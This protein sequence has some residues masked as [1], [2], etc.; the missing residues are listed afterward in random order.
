MLDYIVTGAIARKQVTSAARPQFGTSWF[1]RRHNASR[2][3]KDRY[4]SYTGPSDLGSG[5]QRWYDGYNYVT[6]ETHWYQNRRFGPSGNMI[7]AVDDES[8][9]KP[10]ALGSMHAGFRSNDAWQG[11]EGGPVP[12]GRFGFSL[13]MSHVDIPGMTIG[14]AFKHQADVPSGRY[15]YVASGDNALSQG[16][17]EFGGHVDYPDHKLNHY[18]YQVYFSETG[19]TGLPTGTSGSDGSTQSTTDFRSSGYSFVAGDIGKFIKVTNG[20]SEADEYIYEITG[21]NGTDAVTDAVTVNQPF[22]ASPSTA[23]NMVWEMV[24]G[25]IA[26]YFWRKRAYKNWDRPSAAIITTY[27]SAAMT[28]GNNEA[29]CTVGDPGTHPH[30]SAATAAAPDGVGNWWFLNAMTNYNASYYYEED[31]AISLYRYTQMSPEGLDPVYRDNDIT[32]MPTGIQW[33]RDLGSDDQHDIWVAWEGTPDAPNANKRVAK[34][35]PHPAGDARYPAVAGAGAALYEAQSG[36]ADAT[37]LCSDVPAGIVCDYLNG[38]TWIFHDTGSTLAT[39]QDN[40]GISYTE[41]GGTTWKRIHRLHTITGETLTPTNGV[42]TVTG[43]TALLSKVAPGDWIRFAGDTRSYEVD[44][45]PDNA[46]LTLVINY[47]G[48]GGSPLSVEKGALNGDVEALA[49]HGPW[50]T[51]IIGWN[52]DSNW[53]RRLAADFDRSGNVYWISNDRSAVMKWSPTD[54]TVTKI[55]EAGLPTGGWAFAGNQLRSV[56][57]TKLPKLSNRPAARMD[58]NIWVCSS[59]DG[60]ARIPNTNFE[61]VGDTGSMTDNGGTTSFADLGGTPNKVQVHST[62]H[63]LANGCE[64]YISGTTNYNGEYVIENVTADTFDIISPYVAEGVAGSWQVIATKYHYNV[65]DNYPLTGDIPSA[66]TNRGMDIAADETSGAIYLLTSYAGANQQHWYMEQEGSNRGVWTYLGGWSSASFTNVNNRKEAYYAYAPSLSMTF[67]RDN[68]SQGVTAMTYGTASANVVM[69]QGSVWTCFGWDGAAW[70]EMIGNHNDVDIDFDA[71]AGGPYMAE[72][73][74][75]GFGTRRVFSDWVELEHGLMV[76]FTQDGTVAQTSEF[77]QDEQTTVPVYVGWGKDNISDA[78]YSLGFMWSPTVHRQGVE[79]AGLASN[80]WLEDGPDYDTMGVDGGFEPNSVVEQ[81]TP[82]WE[83]GVAGPT[84]AG[85][86]YS[87]FLNVLDE[88]YGRYDRAPDAHY[89][90]SLR[91]RP[92]LELASDYSVTN[93]SDVFTTGGGHTFTAGDLYKTIQIEGSGATTPVNGSYVITE[94]LTGT[95]VRVDRAFDDTEAAGASQRWKL[96][97]IPAVGYVDAW[98]TAVT[99]QDI[100]ATYVGYKLYSSVDRGEAWDLVKELKATNACTYDEAL[101]NYEDDGVFISSIDGWNHFGGAV[102][103]IFDLT[104]LDHV[105][106][107]RTYWK[108][109]RSYSSSSYYANHSS[110]ILRDDNFKILG[111]PAH[112]KCADA[113][114]PQFVANYLGW[115]GYGPVNRK[116][117]LL[118]PGTDQIQTVD[119]GDGDSY[120]NQLQMVSGSLYECSGTNG[121]SDVSGTPN[122]FGAP[123]VFTATGSSIAVEGPFSTTKVLTVTTT[124][125]LPQHV[126]KL[127][128]I[129]GSG[130]GNDG[131]YHIIE[132]VSSSQVKYHDAGGGA[133]GGYSGTVTL[134]PFSQGDVGKKLRLPGATPSGGG[135]FTGWVTITGLVDELTATIDVDL[136]PDTGLTWALCRFGPGDRLYLDDDY[137]LPAE[138]VGVR[139]LLPVIDDVPTATT[140][141]VL[142]DSIPHVSPLTTGVDFNIIR[143][144]PDSVHET[145]PGTSNTTFD[146]NT[147]FCGYSDPRTGVYFHSEPVQFLEL[148]GSPV[149]ACFTVTDGDGDLRVE[150]IR[151]PAALNSPGFNQV[152][153]GDFIEV[154]GTGIG[155]RF[156]EIKDIP[157]DGAA[158]TAVITHLDE[159]PESLSGL[160]CRILRRKFWKART[161]KSTTTTQETIV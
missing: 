159:F 121:I 97:D 123:S 134:Y 63:G 105:D 139:E 80:P 62:A 108:L 79:A 107:R 122:T 141:T 148:S 67:G 117:V 1:F 156:F 6:G 13:K 140:M 142:G 26:E 10:V 125:F 110:T 115:Y 56:V 20:Q 100:S 77:V 32:D 29:R 75:L 69:H 90:V 98:V 17:V 24:T 16:N 99:H 38:V 33:W 138:Y 55:L 116:L 35:D 111:A 151:I 39:D 15:F 91:I 59:A 76:K 152:V 112:L 130:S 114:D 104:A 89:M 42:K 31:F 154:T 44:T 161:L 155:R 129:A 109:W 101:T 5:Y 53:N 58:D 127:I 23:T 143:D 7:I 81:T 88:Y 160:S 37:G 147:K 153:P 157:T 45:V 135:D 40:G 92:E 119:D 87:P 19:G 2:Y 82:E 93:A 18:V 113:D 41:D 57:V 124:P 22:P 84:S 8:L 43:G 72:D 46:N 27:G 96:I 74:S 137:F 86:R 78:E 14:N 71:S 12:D 66:S 9:A 11:V 102:R 61:Y 158:T 4:V 48:T 95:T 25:P 60:I 145:A 103:V 94:F 28:Y 50:E 136:D 52:S 131:T 85:S 34:I 36:L 106:R 21:I 73:V 146:Y 51:T 70:G 54:G 47:Q 118:D 132:Y 128:N 126:G 65:A 149:A 150:D 30:N 83:L 3:T 120:T 68:V 49:K 64:I 144:F 133:E